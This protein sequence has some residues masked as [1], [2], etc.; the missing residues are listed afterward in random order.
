MCVCVWW[1]EC[2]GPRTTFGSWLS[3]RVLGIELRLSDMAGRDFTCCAI[4]PIPKR[5]VFIKL[6]S[7]TSW[8]LALFEVVFSHS[9]KK[10]DHIGNLSASPACVRRS[11]AL[12]DCLMRVQALSSPQFGLW[13]LLVTWLLTRKEGQ[14][15]KSWPR[16]SENGWS[17]VSKV[18]GGQ[19]C[20]M[21]GSY[22]PLYRVENLMSPGF[23]KVW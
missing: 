18:L 2:G 7:L 13:T 5:L 3:L 19:L 1:L 6:V 23:S 16:S 8:T 4:L 10:T 14:R 17:S 22:L 11:G 15:Y 21:S 12:K 9:S 20:H